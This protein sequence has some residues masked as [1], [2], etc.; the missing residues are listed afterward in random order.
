M[1]GIY[2]IITFYIIMVAT[3][4]K[5][6]H[7]WNDETIL[8]GIKKIINEIGHFP[9]YVELNNNISVAISRNGGINKFRKLLGYEQKRVPGYWTESKII[10]ELNKIINIAGNFPSSYELREKYMYLV[11]AM[12]RYGGIVK[13]KKLLG[14]NLL[15]HE[16][17][18]WTEEK[19]IEKLKE[20]KNKIGHFPKQ[21]ELWELG[22]STI[23]FTI[24][25]KGNFNRF[26]ML[27]G[28]NIIKH[29]RNYWTEEKTTEI[30]LELIRNIGYFPMPNEFVKL[31]RGEL[32]S[33]ISKNG[34]FF[35][36]RTKLGCNKITFEMKSYYNR[37]G[38]KS[39]NIIK[40]IIHDYCIL[41]EY[42]EP[43]YN[44]KLAKG[45]VIEFICNTGK[46]I[47]IDVTN[48]KSNSSEDSI[49][50]KYIKKEYYK[51]VDEFWIVIFTN[52]FTNKD[53]IRLNT[54]AIKYLEQKNESSHEIRIMSIEQ[55]LDELNYSMD[56]HMRNKIELYKCCN[57]RNRNDFM[58]YLENKS[59]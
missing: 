52:I 26:R 45:N 11:G 47:G 20:I 18:Y 58:I 57:F 9:S 51:Y 25:K 53:Y 38:K 3:K 13:F 32:V 39:E 48:T 31:G 36:F 43:M 24:N 37:R 44:K 28:D 21:I 4:R 33:A 49:K 35:K 30:L 23:S 50:R 1:F 42:P 22:Y 15:H 5:P 34:G 10:D 2:F 59:I 7:Y 16:N 12:N 17:N 40:T 19:I 54:D 14:Y 8:D 6:N 56:D 29:D 55:F 46:S 41:N 27:L